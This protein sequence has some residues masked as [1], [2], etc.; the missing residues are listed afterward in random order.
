LSASEEAG[1]EVETALSKRMK[2]AKAMAET[3]R[4]ILRPIYLDDTS[5]QVL[6]HARHFAQ[7]G[8]GSIYLLHVVPT[9]EL[10][11]LRKVY[12][13]DG[14]G[15]AAVGAAEWIAR[16]QLAIITQFNSNPAAGMRDARK[17]VRA[18]LVVVTT[19]A[20]TGFAHPI[21]GSVAEKVV[22]E[23]TCSVLIIRQE[24]EVPETASLRNLPP[25][26]VR[27]RLRNSMTELCIPC[28]WF[29]PKIFIS[30]GRWII[31]EK[32]WGRVLFGQRR[33]PKNGWPKFRKRI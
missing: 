2:K 18:D 6:P 16:E 10:H 7:S 8:G 1:G 22:R 13:P 11:L 26:S 4:N 19:H 9:D 28:M 3:F 15:G 29:R 25:S 20:R 5:P 23:F 12:R 24:D 14:R 33:L 31:P 21:L 30:N 27:G 17:E 32:A